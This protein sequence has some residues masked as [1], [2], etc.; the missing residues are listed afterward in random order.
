MKS[1]AKR[2]EKF[3]LLLNKALFSLSP[4]AHVHVLIDLD[5]NNVWAAAHRAV[6]DIGLLGYG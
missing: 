2:S 5:M 1:W 4:R 6:F 3:A